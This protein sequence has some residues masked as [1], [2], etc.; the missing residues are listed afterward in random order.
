MILVGLSQV[1]SRPEP[2]LY[3]GAVDRLLV[4]VFLQAHQE[5]PEEIILAATDDPLHGQQEGRFFHGCY[6]HYCYLPL[7]NFCGDPAVCTV[8]IIEHRCLSGKCRELQRIVAQIRSAWPQ[9]R[10]VV[11]GDSGFCREGLMAWCEANCV[12]YLLGLVKN[13][14]L[15]VEIAQEMGRRKHSTNRPNAR[16]GCSKN[17]SIRRARSGAVRDGWWLR[18]SIWKRERIRGSW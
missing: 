12:E 15:Q 18:P 11:R 14:R 9:V 5:A 2:V 10:L 13:E 4:E 6:G 1:V 16:L 17:S 7:Y 8:A 3:H